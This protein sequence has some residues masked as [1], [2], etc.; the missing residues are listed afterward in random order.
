MSEQLKIFTA[1]G[2]TSVNNSDITTLQMS[3]A[4]GNLALTNSVTQSADL[5]VAVL[6]DITLAQI[7]RAGPITGATIKGNIKADGIQMDE[8][9]T[10][11]SLTTQWGTADITDLKKGSLSVTA[12][13]G[14]AK[15]QI[16]PTYSGAFNLQAGKSADV[17]SSLNFT[18]TTDTTKNKLGSVN[19][20]RG[21]SGNIFAKTLTGSVSLK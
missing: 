8:E 11:I 3:I 2:S 18:L 13:A 14:D 19:P 16:Y 21:G 12:N 7:Q 9:T 17:S 1:T 10:T 4:S 5:K 20:M 15:V 6:G